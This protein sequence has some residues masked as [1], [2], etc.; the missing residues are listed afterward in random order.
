M[1]IFNGRHNG[2]HAPA[3]DDNCRRTP[4]QF[5]LIASRPDLVKLL[6]DSGADP[7]IRD[8]DGFAALHYCTHSV[9]LARSL[10]D[11]GVDLD[12]RTRESQHALL[13]FSDCTSEVM[14]ALGAVVRRL[15][16]STTS[17]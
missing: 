17:G 3:D 14:A 9:A 2:P 11:A 4:L 1:K 7:T 16:P 15:M 13:H 8:K 6:L 5:A 10:I 12:I